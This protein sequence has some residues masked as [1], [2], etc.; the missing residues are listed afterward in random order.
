MNDHLCCPGCRSKG[1]VFHQESMECGNCRATFPVMWGIPMLI[2]GI[3]AAKVKEAFLS[4][5]RL[6]DS[7]ILGIE[8]FKLDFHMKMLFYKFMK[9]TFPKLKSQY[10]YWAYRGKDYMDSFFDS[11]YIKLEIFFQ[12]MLVE[13]LKRLEWR[14]FFE[15]GCGFGWNIKRVKEEFPQS[16]VGGIDFSLPQLY[17]GRNR[18][19]KE[20][21]E[22]ATTGGDATNIPYG[23]GAF[24]IGFSLG[25][26]MNIHPSA[27]RKAISE[28]IRVSKKYIIHLEY[29]EMHA[30]RE[31]CEKRRPKTNI[32]SHDYAALYKEVGGHN[33]AIAKFLDYRDFGAACKAFTE[34]QHIQ[35]SRWEKW[36]GP[37]KYIFI[38][39]RKT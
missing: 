32:I 29:D 39:V 30:T 8:K 15:A 25:V 4:E 26:F 31:L 38:V 11:D 17:S 18:Y 24:D 12:N 3:D 16:T 1:L 5:K 19:H 6:F 13:E 9:M 22:I 23:D 2:N 10:E 14:S 34:S 21:P 35:F 28:M 33:V 36:E 37:S 20:F 27:I 7:S